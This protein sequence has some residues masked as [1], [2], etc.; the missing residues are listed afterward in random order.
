MKINLD[1]INDA[2]YKHAKFYY[3]ILYTVGYTKIKKLIKFV[4]LKYTYSDLDICQ[5]CAVQNTKY[6]LRSE[7]SVGDLVQILY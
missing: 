5:F 3:E 7:I 6:P 2:T 4:D 1:I